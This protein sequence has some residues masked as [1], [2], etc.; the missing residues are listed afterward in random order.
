M[1][2][3]SQHLTA[4]T[5]HIKSTTKATSSSNLAGKSDSFHLESRYKQDLDDA[6]YIAKGLLTELGKRC[7]LKAGKWSLDSGLVAAWGRAIAETG[8]PLPQLSVKLGRA[9]AALTPGAYPPDIGDL[10]GHA[11]SVIDADLA[12]SSFLRACQASGAA[13]YYSLTPAELWAGRQFGW[14]DLKEASRTERNINRWRRLLEEA[15]GRKDL[16]EPPLRPVAVITDCS[17]PRR[18]IS[19]LW[20]EVTDR[21]ARQTPP[22]PNA[23]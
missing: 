14:Q 12:E 13:A 22:R 3:L 10:L 19:E 5:P 16:P 1:Q 18:R 4:V 9:L 15:A 23:F 11:L 17:I 21:N 6:T 7:P 20:A 8:Q 2:S